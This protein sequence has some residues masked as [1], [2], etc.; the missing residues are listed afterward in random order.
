MLKQKE[1]ILKMILW[2]F[3]KNKDLGKLHRILEV[4]KINNKINHLLGKN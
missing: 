3:Y 1:N 4:P 2:N